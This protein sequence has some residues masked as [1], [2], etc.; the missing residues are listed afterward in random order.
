MLNDK[1][2]VLSQPWTSERER[3]RLVMLLEVDTFLI[4][5][6]LESL[7][8]PKTVRDVR[9]RIKVELA[10]DACGPAPE[11]SLPAPG[12][13]VPTAR[14]RMTL[15]GNEIGARSDSRRVIDAPNALDEVDTTV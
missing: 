8:D 12:D 7:Q 6:S 15:N 13:H 1:S 2:H 3:G 5:D 4:N 9:H 10:I 14:S 11:L